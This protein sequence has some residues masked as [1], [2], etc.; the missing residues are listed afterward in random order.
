MFLFFFVFLYLCTAAGF[1]Y[2]L[3][4]LSTG[5]STTFLTIFLGVDYDIILL[6]IWQTP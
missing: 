2:T 6:F 3:W 1:L 4:L 5:A